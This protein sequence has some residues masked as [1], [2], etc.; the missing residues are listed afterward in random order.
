ML[1]SL[2][3]VQ[4]PFE[5]SI[6]GI[7]KRIRGDKIVVCVDRARGVYIRK[8]TYYAYGEKIKYDK[9][10]QIAGDSS[11]NILCSESLKFPE[12]CELKR[13]DDKTFLKRLCTNFALAVLSKSDNSE[14]LKIGL[15][16]P[17]GVQ[18]D[19]LPHLMNYS[20]N[21]AVV[22]NSPNN[23]YDVL[24][25]IM[26]EMG[27]C[28]IVT[29][30]E[31]EL[32]NCD[33]VIAPQRI[34][35]LIEFNEKALILTVGRPKV[36]VKGNLYY[37]YYIKMPNGFDRIK[38]EDLSNEYFCSALYYVAKQHRLGS[39]IPQLCGNFSFTQTVKS[40]EK[41]LK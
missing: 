25:V 9:I 12:N 7:I 2:T 20:S 16:D 28:A 34:N 32:K 13:F 17:D 31:N 4:V 40:A 24:E 29:M 5:K 26:E 3:I 1:T 15:Y 14:K 38:P 36:D 39:I 6:K 10:F 23:Y 8:I 22:T 21:V 27:A 33:L 35:R 30:N 19:L 18:F 11:Y 41:L 37:K